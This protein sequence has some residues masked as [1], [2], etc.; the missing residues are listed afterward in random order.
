MSPGKTSN[1]LDESEVPASASSDLTST[2]S[3]ITPDE[4]AQVHARDV[5]D[6]PAL[7][8]PRYGPNS[9]SQSRWRW[10]PLPIRR[11]STAITKWAEG[12]RPPR[13]HKINPFFPRVQTA[14]MRLLD[15]FLPKQKHR[16]IA[17]L[18]VY[19]CW[20][21]I[22]VT[23]LHHS[24][25]ENDIEGYGTPVKLSCL[26]TFWWPSNGCG[27]D[28]N[29]CRPFDN[30]SIAFRC[31]ANCYRIQVLNP[32][33]VGTEEVNYRQL[34]IGGPKEGGNGR[35]DEQVYRSDSFICGAA[36]H[37]GAITDRKGGCGV[38]HLVGQRNDYP[39][40]SRNGISSIGFD[41]NFPSSYSF[42]M[43][44]LE[45]CE[46]LRWP[47]LGVSVFFTCLISLFTS[48]PAVFFGTMFAGMFVHVGLV[49]DP[50][51]S[52]N[53]YNIVSV[54]IGRF[55]PSAFTGFVLYKYCVRRTLTG[56]TA[57]IEK[58]VLWVGGCWV[59][60]LTNYTFDFIPISRLTPHDLNQQ[61]GAKAALAI[62]IICLLII[63]ACQIWYFR[64]EGRLL[65]Y[66]ALYAVFGICLGLFGAIPNL[67]LRIHHY[68]LAILLLP[69]TSMQTRPSL[70][71]QGILVG[72]F[73]NGI[74]RWGFASLLQ[75]PTELL[76][77]A[78][79]NSPLP[80]IDDPRITTS[81][82]T[83]SWDQ[84]P[85]VAAKANE[86]GTFDGVSVLVNDVE[87]YRGYEADGPLVF[88]WE[89]RPDE[90]LRQ[91]FR[92]AYMQGSD[93]ADYTKAGIWE[94]DGEWKEMEAGPSKR[95]LEGE[96]ESPQ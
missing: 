36:I 21:L 33:A 14:P 84:R 32:H 22:F 55:L 27:V 58:T 64:Q 90:K 63:V 62:I 88:T 75:T 87:R 43:S 47:L 38:L 85:S 26:D 78:Q 51:Y 79:T 83:F 56:L 74:A 95:S 67:N 25:F 28:G 57:Q 17:L 60:A 16:L 13:I 12:P 91:Y 49:S 2:S 18:A 40:T 23:L 29:E 92:F 8:S 39:S 46:D 11:V 66:L 45:D 54:L 94:V 41:S 77:G 76:Q 4:T 69:G 1:H 5:D 7:P 10:V 68:I 65:K 42:D 48:D 9:S 73:I 15:R 35:A 44:L 53:Y 70:L 82:I 96:S 89:R 52:S 93:P 80:I 3:Q 19:F 37:A 34:V 59:G 81:N 72:F 50:P 6:D 71:Y 24:A 61:P 20:L 30:T 31:P 86:N